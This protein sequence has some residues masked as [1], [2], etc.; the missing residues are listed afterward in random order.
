MKFRLVEGIE[1]ELIYQAE[2]ENKIR[3]EIEKM[4]QDNNFDVERR[5]SGTS[6]T[7]KQDDVTAMFYIN[8]DL[9]YN[10]YVTTSENNVQVNGTAQDAI[11]NAKSIIDRYNSYTM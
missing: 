2:R 9:N 6:Y 3:Y 5:I 1:D 8:T 10:G 11:Q 7:A 4:F